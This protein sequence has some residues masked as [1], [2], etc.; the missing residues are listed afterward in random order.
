MG[1]EPAASSRAMR[2]SLTVIDAQP[3]SVYQA[4]R[5]DGFAALAMTAIQF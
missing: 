4:G 3:D 2:S 5:L 1:I